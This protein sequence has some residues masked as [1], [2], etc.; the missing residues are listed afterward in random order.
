MYGLHPDPEQDKLV[1]PAF[2]QLACILLLSRFHVHTENT[3]ALLEGHIARFG[4]LTKVLEY[5]N[6]S[7]C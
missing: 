2:R 1:I 7:L 4:E 5:Y 3:L 6:L